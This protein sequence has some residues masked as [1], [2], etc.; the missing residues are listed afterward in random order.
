VAKL[1]ALHSVSGDQNGQPTF[2]GTA[3]LSGLSTCTQSAAQKGSSMVQVGQQFA[4]GTPAPITG[5]YRHTACGKVEDFNKTNI[6]AP[7]ANH[8][9]PNRG[10]NWVLIQVLP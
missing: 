6:L 7:C 4:V 8:Q 3:A 1:S 9:C 10:A 5:L 2:D